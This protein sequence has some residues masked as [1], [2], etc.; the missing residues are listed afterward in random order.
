MDGEVRTYVATG[1][2][3]WGIVELWCFSEVLREESGGIG[4][5]EREGEEI[6]Y[7]EEEEKGEKRWC[8]HRAKASFALIWCHSLVLAFAFDLIIIKLSTRFAFFSFFF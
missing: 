6:N 4:C 5:S 1:R 2:T 7:K 3:I 8:T